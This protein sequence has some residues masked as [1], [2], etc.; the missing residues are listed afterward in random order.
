MVAL[1]FIFAGQ[2]VRAGGKPCEKQ[3]LIITGTVVGYD[4]LIQLANITSA[5]QLN[6]LLVTP[7]FTLPYQVEVRHRPFEPVVD[8]GQAPSARPAQQSTRSAIYAVSNKTQN[9]AGGSSYPEAAETIQVD[10][11]YEA[12][13]LAGRIVD[14]AG[15]GLDK[16][17][18]ERLGS[19]WKER[20]DATF[21]NAEGTFSFPRAPVKTQ[22][23]RLSKPGFN[24]SMIKVRI[25]RSLKAQLKVE[26]NLSQ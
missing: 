3:D 21:T 14:P 22:F 20:L 15:S 16:V 11:P 2:I 18:V 7:V 25:K 4:Q 24:T 9:A 5:P 12:H 13:A 8:Y 10:V 6:V 1:G 26:L 23:L 17:L 19:G